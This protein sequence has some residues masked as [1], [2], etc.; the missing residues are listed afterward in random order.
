MNLHTRPHVGNATTS[1][2]VLLYD[3]LLIT[4]E[5]EWQ[6]RPLTQGHR[7]PG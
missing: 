3:H 2:T 1:E 4:N 6:M 7:D 5:D